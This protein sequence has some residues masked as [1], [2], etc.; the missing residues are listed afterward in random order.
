M[1]LSTYEISE[2]VLP[3]HKLVDCEFW[4]LEHCVLNSHHRVL[5][6][7]SIVQDLTFQRFLLELLPDVMWNGMVVYW[8]PCLLLFH[9]VDIEVESDMIMIG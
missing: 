3:P 1:T 5:A 6:F 4:R 2:E 8:Q 9:I 7:P